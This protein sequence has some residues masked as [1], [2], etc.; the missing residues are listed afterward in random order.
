M[1][2]NPSIVD[3]TTSLGFLFFHTIAIPLQIPIKPIFDAILVNDTKV[4]QSII[5]EIEYLELPN[6]CP[7][8]VVCHDGDETLVVLTHTIQDVL[9]CHFIELFTHQTSSSMVS[10]PSRSSLPEDVPIFSF[11]HPCVCG[12]PSW[13]VSHS[14]ISCTCSHLWCD[15]KWVYIQVRIESHPT[16]VLRRLC[17]Q[18]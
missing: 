1:E 4:S 11:Y 14:S 6:M 5:C 17:D 15:S 16:N 18:T 3:I 2:T 10:L 7:H 12:I 13:F 8:E 9:L